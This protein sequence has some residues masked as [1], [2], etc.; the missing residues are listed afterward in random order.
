Q[1]IKLF[2]PYL[3]D[4]EK[5][6]KAKNELVYST[7]QDEDT[8]LAISVHGCESQ[9][10][11]TQANDIAQKVIDCINVAYSLFKYPLQ[12]KNWNI[13]EQESHVFPKFYETDAI[14]VFI[15]NCKQNEAFSFEPHPNLQ[16]VTQSDLRNIKI[17]INGMIN[18]PS[19]LSENILMKRYQIA[20]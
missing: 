1:R 12:I 18:L 6:K 2:K 9:K 16:F 7:V 17:V 5:F 13:N 3:Q 14:S 15:N 20:F 4:K 11:Y 10:T 8:A 19:L